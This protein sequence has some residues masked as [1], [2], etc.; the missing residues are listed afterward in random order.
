M[1]AAS[2][3]IAETAHNAIVEVARILVAQAAA[4]LA[5]VQTSKPDQART[6][7]K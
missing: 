7:S 6:S 3:F 5:A 4:D 1:N 2:N